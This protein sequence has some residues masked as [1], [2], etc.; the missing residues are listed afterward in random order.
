M[1]FSSGNQPPGQRWEGVVVEL[2]RLVQ[3]SRLHLPWT[4]LHKLHVKSS[5]IRHQ[6]AE[7]DFP[8]SIPPF[9]L[10]KSSQLYFLLFR[11]WDKDVVV[12]PLMARA[13]HS[14]RP[15]AEFV[16]RIDQ[17]SPLCIIIDIKFDENKIKVTTTLSLARCQR[18]A[19]DVCDWGGGG[20]DHC[21]HKLRQSKS[22][23]HRIVYLLFLSQKDR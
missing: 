2:D 12:C 13:N 17:G 14:C 21:N 20:G 10:T 4:L 1:F 3:P 8:E 22:K 15:N 19:S 16:A 5:T 6:N 11:S 18:V 7:T 23:T 9:Q